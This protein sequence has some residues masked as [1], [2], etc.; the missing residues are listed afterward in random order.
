LTK[1]RT[2]VN[3]VILGCGRVGATLALQ[4][5]EAGNNVTIIDSRSDAFQRLGNKFRGEKVL[6]NGVDLD[7]L[8][9]AGIESADA[10]AAV[11]NGDNRNIMA[12]QIAKEIFN[13][14]KVVCRIYDPLRERTFKDLGLETICPTILI[15]GLVANAIEGKQQPA[16]P[17]SQS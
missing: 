13:V 4:L 14:K 5:E 10:F 15:S 12:S 11:T 8:K 3:I 17:T 2:T 7:V 9:R 16:T 1:E 6:G